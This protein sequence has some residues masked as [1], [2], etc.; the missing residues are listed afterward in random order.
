MSDTIILTGASGLVGPHVLV[1]LSDR[2]CRIIAIYRSEENLKHAQL[3]LSHYQKDPSRIEWKRMDLLK[4]ELCEEWLDSSTILIHAAAIVSF[5]RKL[6]KKMYETN[7]QLTARL[8]NQALERKIKKMIHL[9]SI[10]VLGSS[11]EGLLNEDSFWNPDDSHSFYAKTKFWGELEVWRGIEEGLNAVILN[12]GFILGEGN[13][14]Q[15]SLSLFNMVRKGFSYYPPGSNGFVGVKDV[16][17]AVVRCIDSAISGK[18][19]ILVS[20]NLSYQEL[21]KTIADGLGISLQWKKAS[22]LLAKILAFI[23]KIKSLFS[24]EE[25]LLTSDSVDTAFRMYQYDN[26]TSRR[27]LQL[28][29]TPIRHVINESIQYLNQYYFQKH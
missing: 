10:A 21:L 3:L 12:P 7:V 16:A 13:P 1:K 8:V 2:P 27:L 25:P 29:Y 11:T 20:E 15:S 28:Q 6:E 19:I 22:Y 17:E 18:R 4:E 14:Y 5:N 26:E 9:S 23:E 24:N